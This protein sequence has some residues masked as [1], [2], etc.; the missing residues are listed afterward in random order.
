VQAE[1]FTFQ[2][3]VNRMMKLIIN[4][5]Y[6]NKEIFLRELISNAS[7]AI[8]KIRLLALSNSKELETNPELHIRIKADKENKALHI[9]DS[10]IGMTHQDLINNLGTIAKSGTADFLAKMQDPSKSEGLDMN[11]MIGQFGVG[12]YSA[13]LV[14]DR[15]VVTTKHNDDKQY[16][17][18]SDANSFSITEDPRGDTL[19]RGS[20]ISLYLKEEAQDFLEEDTVRELIRKYSQFI[21]F[22]IRMWSSKTVEEEVPVEEEAKPEKSED[23]VEDEDAKVEEAEDEK[24]KT[25]KVSKTTWDWT[26]IN[27]SKPIWTRKPA[28]V[29]EDEYT[30]FYKSLTKDSSEPLTQTHFIAEGEVT[31]KSLLYVPKVQPSESHICHA[32]LNR[33]FNLIIN[34]R[35]IRV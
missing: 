13:F 21:N 2:T 28:E 6:R 10:G 7:D 12:F 16:I 17:W 26:L 33:C 5:L 35:L 31:F 20:V 19:K 32:A 24:P 1:K 4:S 8:D 22:P 25:K 15:V 9:M 27:D 29:T 14:A 23:D 30:S 18:E 11:D 34:W 3:E